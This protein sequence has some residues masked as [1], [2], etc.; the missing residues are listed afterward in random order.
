MVDLYVLVVP[1]AGGDVLQGLKRGIVE[2]VDIVLVRTS[3]LDP[4]TQLHTQVSFECLITALRYM[5][6]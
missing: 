6:R 2:L 3:A 5:A 4:H 1:P